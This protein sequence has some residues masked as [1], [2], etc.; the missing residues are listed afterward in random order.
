MRALP[1]EEQAKGMALLCMS[2]AK[3][4]VDI[5]TQCDWGYSLGVGEW[6][7]ASGRFSATPDPLMGA[8]W[9]KDQQ[10]AAANAK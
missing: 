1:Q 7:G 10:P 4:D 2:R 3:S 5:E 9:E 6:Q 8:K